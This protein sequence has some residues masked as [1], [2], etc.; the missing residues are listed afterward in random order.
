MEMGIELDNCLLRVVMGFALVM[1]SKMLFY[2]L[3]IICVLARA[4]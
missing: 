2:V 1:F 3:S 4:R